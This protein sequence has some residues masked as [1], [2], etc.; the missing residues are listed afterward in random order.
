MGKKELVQKEISRIY[1][2]H[3]TAKP[4]LVLNEAKPASS[5]LHPFFEWDDA[6]AGHNYRIVQARHLI[7]SVEIIRDDGQTEKL[8]HVP[9]VLGGHLEGDYKPISAVVA[10][11]SEYDRALGSLLSQLG[12]LCETVD[13]LTGMNEFSGKDA[14]TIVR[15]IVNAK[16]AADRMA[17]V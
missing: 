16:R 2:K 17:Q 7:R 3:G 4:S 15:N 14:K 11:Q 5:P 12:G 8:I 6:K 13:G 9:N 1:R 10:S